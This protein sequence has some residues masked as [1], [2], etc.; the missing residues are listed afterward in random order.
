MSEAFLTTY[1]Q[2]VTT[3]LGL[4]WMAF[5]AFGLGYLISAMIQVFV[6]KERMKKSM[7]HAEAKSMALGTFFGFVSSSC[8]FSALS[9]TRSLFT[10]GAG[11][12]PSLAFLLASTNLVIEL[13]II[14]AVFLSWQFV[15]AEY[16][17]GL[18]LI[19]CV[20][21]LVKLWLPKNLVEQAREHAQAEE[22]SESNNSVPDWRKL[23]TSR[24]GWG[25]VAHKYVMEWQMVW[26]DVTV[27]FTVAGMIAAFVP[28]SFFQQLF[29][30]AGTPNPS[31][32][33]VLAQ[34]VVGPVAAFF[35]FI[36]S[37]GNIPLAAV[38]FGNGV[39]FAGIMAFIFSDLVVFPVLRIQAKY[40]GW[41]MAFYILGL[42]LVAL[43]ST[44]LILHYGFAAF[45]LLPD[46]T[47][48]KQMVDRE[49]FH[50]DYTFYLNMFFV[51]M[52]IGFVFWSFK[53]HGSHSM[54]ADRVS[55]KILFWLA[56]LAYV[57]LA[58]GLCVKFFY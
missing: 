11:L 30:G 47:A 25:K 4:F 50:L 40:Y 24:E 14:I 45:D 51:L 22:G 31:F 8:S 36:G 42:F 32:W 16:V 35:T 48:V 15:V 56:S 37:M 44:A 12:L 23:I 53:K 5:W 17:G 19:L 34:T 26:K 43:V 20:W 9:T 28:K 52:S 21:L 38:L 39:A 49:F 46:A 13:G 18:L 57:W 33:E 41:K 55:E 7:G 10:K 3:T 2:A 54:G 29:L 1:S 6:T 27:G 58:V